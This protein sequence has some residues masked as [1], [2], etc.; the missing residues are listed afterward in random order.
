[1]KFS[2][3]I[4]KRYSVRKYKDTPVEE[5]K[6]NAVL[7]AG[8]KAP[9]AKNLQPQKIFVLTKKEELEKMKEATPCTFDA[10]VI[11][12]VCADKDKA[13]SNRYS[14]KISDEMDI[15]IVTTHMMLQAADLGLGSCWV[16]ACDFAKVHETYNLPDNLEA[17][18]LL[19]L[20]Y[21]ADDAEPNERHDNRL[22]LTDTVVK[23]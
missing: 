4:E 8:R 14:G 15:S 10:P 2:E 9:T 3:L 11:L 23:L 1:M 17:H 20:G 12:I 18:C 13:W 22:P 21:P 19:L 6:L 5:E 7:E 16:C